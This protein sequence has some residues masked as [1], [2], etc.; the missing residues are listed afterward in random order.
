MSM[1]TLEYCAFVPGSK[2][3]GCDAAVAATERNGILRDQ[4][5]IAV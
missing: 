1:P 2:A 4:P 3:I 5:P